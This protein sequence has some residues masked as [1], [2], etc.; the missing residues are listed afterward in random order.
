MFGRFVQSI[1]L[2]VIS[3]YRH[4]QL[5]ALSV[6][7]CRSDACHTAIQFSYTVCTA[8][9][10]ACMNLS[11]ICSGVDAVACVFQPMLFQENGAL[12]LG[13]KKKRKSKAGMQRL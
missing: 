3:K 12:T 8:R 10:D 6:G 2:T 5:C 11:Y 1:T 9:V 7:H 4:M 13:G